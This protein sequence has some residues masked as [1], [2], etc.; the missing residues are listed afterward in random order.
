M[1]NILITGGAGYIGSHISEILIK[2]NKNIFIV[3]NLSTGFK[4][5]INKN[6]K[7]Y[8][9]NIL[10]SNEIKK[11]LIK[12]KIDSVIHLAGSLII[13]LGEK[14]PKF[15]YKNNVL[16]TKSV[17]LACKN[18]FVK[19]FIFSSTAAV[20]QDKQKIV[21]EESKI[22]PKSVYGK[23]KIKAEKLIISNCKKIGINYAILR[24]F[25]V[26][27]ASPSGKIGLISKTD[28]LFKNISETLMKKKP[29]IKI[30]GNDYNTPDGTAIRDYIH[31]SD[32]A[33]V[34]FKILKKI[35][36]AN[37]ST[38]INCG[39]N[40]GTSVKEVVDEFKKQTK[41][42][43][44]ISYQKK[45]PGDLAMIIANNKKLKKI[46]NWSPKYNNLNT[47]VKSCIRWEKI[48]NR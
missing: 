30:Y 33:E 25:N 23:T 28:S 8:N 15:Y 7:F 38:I 6:S 17:L 27:G 35:S 39:Y 47:I 34:H 12:F 43:L 46:I 24:Y 48:T 44:N 32:L 37:I 26:C 1:K 31:V 16:G 4:K 36:K 2:K 9:F 42:N 3:D 13:G 45:R 41:K 40:N 21:N 14:Q 22:K 10:D 29:M 5:L 11:I 19:N 18:T 20:Y